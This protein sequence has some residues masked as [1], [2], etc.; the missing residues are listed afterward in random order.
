MAL[1][2]FQY[3][4]F[5]PHN[6][7]FCSCTSNI[8]NSPCVLAC[9]PA[10]EVG[11]GPINAQSIG[12]RLSPSSITQLHSL[13][14]K[15]YSNNTSLFVTA[16]LA[17]STPPYLRILGEQPRFIS[18]INF[19]LTV[20]RNRHQVQDKKRLTP[21]SPPRSLVCLPPQHSI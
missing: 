12:K 10:Q 21:R 6:T 7:M 1:V 9:S 15:D 20:F 16:L 19:H 4:K 2:F 5:S 14:C 13:K 8:F 11:L 3:P 17:N 18:A